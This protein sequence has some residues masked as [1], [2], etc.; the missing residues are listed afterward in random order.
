MRCSCA[1]IA[2]YVFLSSWVVGCDGTIV[3]EG[4][5]KDVDGNP[6]EDAAV[7][8]RTPK[9]SSVLCYA[10]TDNDGH[11]RARNAMT[12]NQANAMLEIEVSADGYVP[13]NCTLRL[14]VICEGSLFVLAE[15]GDSNVPG[16]VD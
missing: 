6:I 15:A 13:V 16:M 1:L 4:Y 11:F 9:T 8:L 10:R 5:V 2:A 14:P 12:P 3:F 7:Q